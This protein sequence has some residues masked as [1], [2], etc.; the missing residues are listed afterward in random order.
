MSRSTDGGRTW[1]SYP[2]EPL[3]SLGSFESMED[4]TFISIAIR[5]VEG[6]P[7]RKKPA[8]VW[9]SSNEGAGITLR[10]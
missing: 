10:R 3:K 5:K 6:E 1:T 2:S 4:G 8:D 9:V 7:Y